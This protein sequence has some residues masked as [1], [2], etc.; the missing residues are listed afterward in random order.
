[1]KGTAFEHKIPASIRIAVSFLSI[2]LL[3]GTG[4]LSS[5][6]SEQSQPAALPKSKKMLQFGTVQFGLGHYTQAS[7][8]FHQV[9]VDDPENTDA[10]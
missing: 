5:I 10:T 2:F 7:V 6:A 4:T 1:M 9:L 8:A 3:S